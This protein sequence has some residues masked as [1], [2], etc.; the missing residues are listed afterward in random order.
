MVKRSGRPPSAARASKAPAGRAAVVHYS[1]YLPE[2]VHEA[3]REAAFN[4]RLKIHD[5]VMQGIEMALK[6]RGYPSMGYLKA[7]KR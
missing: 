2:A 6:K 3:L 4:E 5:I 1:V 7:G